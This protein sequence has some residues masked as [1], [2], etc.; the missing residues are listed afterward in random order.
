MSYISK[1]QRKAVLV[2]IGFLRSTRLPS[3]YLTDLK[4][5]FFFEVTSL[6]NM[7]AKL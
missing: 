2:V 6:P 7:A 4:R 1:V 5:L 3:F